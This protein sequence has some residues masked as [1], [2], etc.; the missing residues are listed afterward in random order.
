MTLMGLSRLTYC[1]QRLAPS[2][3]NSTAEE[4][5]PLE[6]FL[7]F[8]MEETTEYLPDVLDS[9]KGERKLSPSTTGG[10]ASSIVGISRSRTP[11]LN[12]LSSTYPA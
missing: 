10:I 5:I 1:H 11:N 2:S 12:D 3:K 8:T 4:A 7:I 6:S 9:I